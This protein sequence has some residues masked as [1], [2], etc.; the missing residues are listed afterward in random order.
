[1]LLALVPAASAQTALEWKFKEGD[2]F[3]IEA[4]TETKQTVTVSGMSAATSSSTYTTVSQFVVKKADAGSYTLD[5]TIEGIQVKSGK[6]DDPTVGVASRHANLLKGA[7][8]TFTINAAGKIT[9]NLDGYDDF[10]RRQSGGNDKAEKRVRE[11]L[12]E[13]VLKDELSA[14][15]AVL[16]SKAVNTKDTWKRTET[17]VLPWGKLTGESTYT[18]E[19]KDKDGEKIEV[20]QKW[21]YALPEATTSDVKVTKGKVEVSDATGTIVVDPAAG[22]LVSHKEKRHLTGQLTTTDTTKKEITADIDQT[23][24]RTISRVEK[25]PLK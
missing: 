21:S 9:S 14:I 11:F 19:G 6:A 17:V 13:D 25:N 1:L 20:T 5:Q 3:F 7:K 10:V 18:Y 2:K 4:V 24:T 23:T 16:P 12:P 8:F 22:R 15:F